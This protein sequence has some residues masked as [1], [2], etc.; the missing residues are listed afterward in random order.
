MLNTVKPEEAGLSSERLA[1]VNTWAQRLI[2]DGKLAGLTTM[3]AR[4]GKIAHF[5]S[6]GMADLKREQPMAADTILRFYSMTK[7]LT[8]VAIMMLYEEGLFQLDDPITRFLPCFK[9]MRVFSGGMRGKIDTVPAERDITFRDLL[10]HTSGL[11]Y[12]FMEATPVDAQYRESN[13]DFVVSNKSLAEMVEAAAAIPLLAQPG[14]AWNYS[15]ATDVL[16]LLVAVI[17]G[18][19]FDTFL[20]DRIITPLGMTDTAFHVP[21]EKLSRF[22]ANYARGADGRP[23]TVWRG[24]ACANRASW[25][26]RSTPWA[27]PPH[28]TW[29]PSRTRR[30]L[31]P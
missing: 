2:D 11:T 28:P 9:N 19:P 22:A 18:V 26:R 6:R 25:I 15:I 7:P 24:R 12:G 10:S 16:G 3:V 31:C 8:S 4:H 13:I 27:A 20:H 17:S 30:S 23:P 21:D 29:L 5:D 1:R 14:T